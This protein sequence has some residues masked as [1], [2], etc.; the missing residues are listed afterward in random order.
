MNRTLKTILMGLALILFIGSFFLKQLI[1]ASP[2]IADSVIKI[3]AIA[4]L[5]FIVIKQRLRKKPNDIS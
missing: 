3:I 2:E 1:P 4:I 5:A